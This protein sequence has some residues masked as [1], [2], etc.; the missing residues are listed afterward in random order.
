MGPAL[1]FRTLRPEDDLE[2]VA[3]VVNVSFA[4]TGPTIHRSAESLR[5]RYI[6]CPRSGP[7][8]VHL[9]L[10]EGRVVGTAFG[11]EF[12]LLLRGQAVPSG[13]IDDVATL[14]EARRHGVARR[15]VSAAVE[16][17]GARGNRFV[18][19]YANPH[20][21]AHHLYRDLGFR[22]IHRFRM[23]FRPGLQGRLLREKPLLGTVAAPLGALRLRGA[24]R[25]RRTA[26]E[27]PGLD[28][29]VSAF[30]RATKGLDMAPAP[31]A[32]YWEW[33]EKGPFGPRR[34]AVVR[35]G[36]IVAGC[37]VVP[38]GLD[39]WGST[40][41]AH[42][43]GDLFVVGDLLLKSGAGRRPRADPVAAALRVH[44]DCA[45]WVGISNPSSEL[46]SGL[47]RRNG[48]LPFVEH[49]L[50]VKSFAGDPLPS[51][52]NWDVRVESAFGVP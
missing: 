45:L 44:P 28:P 38:Q 13:M 4:T 34:V 48:F 23:W 22:E 46:L 20:E 24:I 29:F 17:L 21:V 52:G 26:P 9:A 35:D 3:R 1:E 43:L 18:V 39:I 11:S 27:V 2:E 36:E 47:F 30:H 41:S 16:Q 42:W 50:M 6:E 31:D 49:M 15:L 40:V 5:W 10:R 7:G 19:L 8:M 37:R 14:P 25:R 32:A 51:P 33:K 12:H